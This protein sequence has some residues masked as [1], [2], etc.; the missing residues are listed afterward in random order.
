[1]GLVL[2]VK[3]LFLNGNNTKLHNPNPPRLNINPKVDKAGVSLL[4]QEAPQRNAITKHNCG[5]DQ[6]EGNDD[7]EEAEGYPIRE[8]YDRLLHPSVWPDDVVVKVVPYIIE[9]PC[10]IPVV[11]YRINK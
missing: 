4:P 6:S 3:R 1:M 11:P 10:I 9:G 8:E 7:P 2:D 5:I